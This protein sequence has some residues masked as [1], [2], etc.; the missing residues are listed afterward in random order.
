[1]TL[2]TWI[3]CTSD[4]PLVIPFSP[5]I[6]LIAEGSIL[7][8]KGGKINMACFG[9]KEDFCV[10]FTRPIGTIVTFKVKHSCFFL[11]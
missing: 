11:R 4:E 10:K 5:I 1:M 2:S 9:N 6:T 3:F 8:L 7:E